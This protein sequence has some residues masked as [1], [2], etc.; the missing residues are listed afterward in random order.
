MEIKM[1]TK[2]A[3]ACMSRGSLFMMDIKFSLC[4][5]VCARARGTIRPVLNVIILTGGR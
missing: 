1:Q 3:F 5:C 2:I 4:V